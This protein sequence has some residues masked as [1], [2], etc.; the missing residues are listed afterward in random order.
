MSR[1]EWNQDGIP[2]ILR[3]PSMRDELLNAAEPRIEL[4]RAA[5]PKRTGLG[6]ASIHAEA[7][8]DGQEWEA[9]VSWTQEH[10]YM[11][12]QEEGWRYRGPHPFLAPAFEF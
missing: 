2:A 9:D 5:A 1:I 6:A 11:K 10:Y 12:F 8:L 4:A 3:D 7:V